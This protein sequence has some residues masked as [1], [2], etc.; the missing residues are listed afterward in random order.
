MSADKRRS[1]RVMLTVPLRLHGT[2][3]KGAPYQ[4]E[5]RTLV[6]NRHGA[7][8]HTRRLLR[9][10]DK[11]RLGSH[12]TRREANFRVV[13]P[14]APFT[15]KGG[16]FGVEYLNRDDNIW[17]IQFPPASG[18]DS[19]D[20]KAIL[21]C[22]RCQ[23]VALQLLSLVEVEVLETSGILTK[24][25]EKCGMQ[26]SWGYAENYL[27]TGSSAEGT[28]TRKIQAETDAVAKGANR[29]RHTRVS[30]QLPVRVR[31]Y[32]G[33][34][35]ICKTENVS[36]GGFCFTSEVSYQVGEGLMMV[37]PYDERA[38]NIEVAA[39]VVRVHP[40]NGSK[41]WVYGIRYESQR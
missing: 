30:L 15:D 26:T 32:Y 5:A 11:V 10:G 18:P 7:R 4:D 9:S 41:R 3:E 2:D 31:N 6:L 13:G 29:R 8:I 25:C 22:R 40:L 17:G 38:Q 14:V 35:E 37:C 36:K 27:G 12:L 33:G 24:T 20:S 39:R 21:E 28:L 23:T 19:Q 1:D 34:V 16:E